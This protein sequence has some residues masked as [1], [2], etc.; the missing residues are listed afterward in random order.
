MYIGLPGVPAVVVHSLCGRVLAEAAGAAATWISPRNRSMF[1]CACELVRQ[2]RARAFNVHTWSSE[3]V[4]V[5]WP[6][7]RWGSLWW[8]PGI[9]TEQWV[10]IF[11]GKYSTRLW[12]IASNAGHG[13]SRCV[14]A[15]ILRCVYKCACPKCVSVCV[16]AADVYK[17]A[18]VLLLIWDNRL[19]TR[20][21]C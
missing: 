20:G 5:C 13:I 7:L 1:A 12:G 19:K 14:K 17:W 16:C 3:C 6:R 8:Y 18:R 10:A 21:S 4:C 9:M 15:F 11:K 2:K